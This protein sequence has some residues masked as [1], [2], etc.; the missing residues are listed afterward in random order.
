MA[1]AA[2]TCVATGSQSVA[3]AC[4]VCDYLRYVCGIPPSGCRQSGLRLARAGPESRRESAALRQVPLPRIVTTPRCPH[5]LRHAPSRIGRAFIPDRT[6][7][8]GARAHPGP[9]PLRKQP[10]NKHVGRSPASYAVVTDWSTVLTE[11]LSWSDA[12]RLSNYIEWCYYSTSLSTV[13]RPI[14]PPCH[15]GTPAGAKP[16]P[17][18]PSGKG[19]PGVGIHP[20]WGSTRRPR[21][22]L[23]P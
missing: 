19:P 11:K 3:S 17:L 15:R 4:A 12:L 13:R 5:E 7:V 6:P 8:R 2:G 9:E 20:E 21:P 18:P 14:E 10:S 23:G 1:A 22:S 16:G